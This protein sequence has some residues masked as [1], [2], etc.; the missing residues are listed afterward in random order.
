LVKYG[1]LNLYKPSGPTSRDCVDRV[2]KCLGQSKI[3]H[4]GTLDP[5]AQGVLLILVGPAVRLMDETH[6]LDKEYVAS[7][8]LGQRSP[9]TDLET[10]CENVPLPVDVDIDAIRNRLP[11]FTGR[12]EQVPSAYS[13]IWV[14]GKRSHQV[15]RQGKPL[16][17]PSRSVTIYELELLALD[18]PEMRL[19]IR[20]STGTYIRTLGSDLAK[21]LGS[22][23]VMTSLM[24]TRVGPFE[25]TSAVS[26]DAL[27]DPI[28]DNLLRPAIDALTG[29]ES[30]TVDDPLLRRILDG[31]RLS[32]EK[33]PNRQGERLA[34][35]DTRE[36]LRAILKRLPDGTWRCDKGIAHWDVFP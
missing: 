22:D 11:Q 15:A 28:P 36:I 3:A 16:Q 25:A 8:Q 4:A 27:A 32:A 29:W 19:R 9:S 13:A 24:R 12:I 17:L 20:C 10:E 33:V 2:G 34:V 26:L 21:S 5:L 7:F 18:L 35:L 30:W 23:A 1:L 31:Q 14:D 6:L